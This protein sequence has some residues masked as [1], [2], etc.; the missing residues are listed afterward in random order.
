MTREEVLKEIDE[1][2]KSFKESKKKINNALCHARNV[3]SKDELQ[4]PYSEA[5]NRGL[6]DA[7]KL[8][9]K[10][11]LDEEDGGMSFNKIF[12]IYA[13][14]EVDI[15]KDFSPQDVM[16]KLEAYEN[17]ISVGDVLKTNYGTGVAINIFIPENSQKRSVYVLYEDGAIGLVD[18]YEETARHIDIQQILKQI[19]GE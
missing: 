7:W 17:E 14:G 6:E 18:E 9:R 15:L 4:I 12:K 2:T 8:A 16:K 5:Y 3:V 1:A 19:E 10:I 13:R 11:I